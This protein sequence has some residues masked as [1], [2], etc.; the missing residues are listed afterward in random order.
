MVFNE[1]KMK[2]IILFKDKLMENN[3]PSQSVE[4]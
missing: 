1:N 4:L 2:L 3:V